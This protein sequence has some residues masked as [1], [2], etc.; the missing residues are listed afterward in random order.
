MGWERNL[1]L[2]E[3]RVGVSALSGPSLAHPASGRYRHPAS[4]DTCTSMCIVPGGAKAG[5]A[6]AVSALGLRSET[7]TLHSLSY[8]VQST[9][10]A[11]PSLVGSNTQSFRQ[12]SR[13]HVTR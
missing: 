1:P 7:P 9:G 2:S 10:T 12:I 4:R 5:P 8:C 3:R 6:N 11:L 13:R